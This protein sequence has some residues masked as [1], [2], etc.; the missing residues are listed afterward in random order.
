MWDRTCSRLNAGAV[1]ASIGYRLAPEHPFPTA[2]EDSFW[3]LRFV[4]EHAAD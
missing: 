1:V 3:G 2:V 4:A